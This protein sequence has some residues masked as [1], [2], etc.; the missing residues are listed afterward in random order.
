MPQCRIIKSFSNP[1][2][3]NHSLPSPAGFLPHNRRTDLLCCT[4]LPN[5][6][7]PSPPTPPTPLLHYT[8]QAAPQCKPQPLTKTS[9]HRFRKKKK[10]GYFILSHHVPSLNLFQFHPIQCHRRRF[11]QKPFHRIGSHP[12]Q[13]RSIHVIQSKYMKSHPIAIPLANPSNHNSPQHLPTPPLLPIPTNPSLPSALNLIHNFLLVKP[14]SR[15][16]VLPYPI[17]AQPASQYRN[18]LR[19]EVVHGSDHNPYLDF[20]R[21]NKGER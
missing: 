10:K 12:I 4:F 6:R 15:H 18:I 9:H 19:K 1:K 3:F 7:S 2:P 17:L 21:R 13:F 8:L 16:P 11:R 14:S 5:D 20:R